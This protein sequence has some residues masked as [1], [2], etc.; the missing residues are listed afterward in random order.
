GIRV[1]VLDG[2]P[3]LTPQPYTRTPGEKT[4]RYDKPARNEERRA[5][6]KPRGEF[7]KKPRFD[8]K[9]DFDK[10]EGGAKPHWKDRED[11]GRNPAKPFA[12]AKPFK[13]KRDEKAGKA[14]GGQHKPKARKPERF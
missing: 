14:E 8:K 10:P 3:D 7:E 4:Q 1:T 12:G 9:R 6:W 2:Q 5:G 11:G 13:G